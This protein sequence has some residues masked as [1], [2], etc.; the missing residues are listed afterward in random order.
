M[1]NKDKISAKKKIVSASKKLGEIQATRS[2]DGKYELNLDINSLNKVDITENA[3]IVLEKRYLFKDKKGKVIETP[4]M[5]LKRVAE[6]IAIIDKDYDEN[7]L[8]EETALNFYNMMASRRFLPNSPTLMNAGR[9]LGQ[10]SACFV[11]PVEDSMDK[12]FE[13]VKNTA[14]IHKSGGGTGFSFSRLR[15]KN[16][17]VHSTAGIS[18]GPLSFMEVFD[19]ATETIKQGGARRGANMAVLRVDHPDIEEF[20]KVKNDLKKLNNFNIS[21]GLTENFMLAAQSG[22]DY[23][24]I[25]PRT[26]E[27]SH[28]ISAKKV[29]DSIVESAWKSGEPGIIFLDR[30]N[31]E[32]PTPQLGEIES[33]NPCGEQ[34]LLPYESCN[35]GSI[36][37]GLFIKEN[38]EIDWDDLGRTVENAVHFLDN[39]IDANKYPIQKIHDQTHSTRKIGLGVMGF[40]DLLFKLKIPYNGEEAMKMAEKLMGFIRET[41]HK[42]STKIAER[43]GNFPA[44]EGSIFDK[45]GEKFRRN[46][47]I[48]TIAPTGTISIIASASSGIEPLFA[49]AYI[50]TVLDGTKM[51]E[52]HSLFKDELKKIGIYTDKLM[53]RVIEEGSVKH[54]PEIPKDVQDVYVTSHDISPL[55]HIKIQAAFQKH[56]DNAVSKT[57]NFPKTATKDE[58]SEVY[59]LANMLSCKGITIYRDGSRAEQ[60]LSTKKTEEP[61]K[62]AQV[63][64]R[65]KRM[66]P[67]STHGSTFK[68]GTGCGSLYVTVNNDENGICEVFS[69]LGKSGGCA[70]SQAEAVS[71]MVSLALRSGI[72]T[73]EIIKQLKG[74]QCP[75]SIWFKG[76]KILSCPDG[77]AQALQWY[78]ESKKEKEMELSLNFDIPSRK[79]SKTTTSTS[80]KAAGSCPECGTTLTR[81]EGCLTCHSCGYSKCS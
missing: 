66:R 69:H 20:I 35:L 23:D 13:T 28:K 49:L 46:A 79:A 76:H 67:D 5:M 26:G 33:T 12:I 43:R 40:A 31:A 72:E 48:T 18:S 24:L 2:K 42:K 60:V 44:F 4:E 73:K 27:K 50:R 34:P 65:D 9:H 52:V 64:H 75:N 77:I 41:G 81:A 47:T 14:L 32:N 55:W 53:D 45:R 16:D 37:L 71:R 59:R 8:I 51:V 17:V 7:S 63:P 22:Q 25:N 54:I 11:L 74:I 10:L 58:I 68:V 39:V 36:N 61:T 80:T 6:H 1:E 38:N 19:S 57:V 30:I 29:F 21:V 3:R 70:A 56:T 78:D 15:P 62:K